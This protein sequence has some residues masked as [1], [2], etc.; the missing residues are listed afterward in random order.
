MKIRSVTCFVTVDETLS[1][2]SLHQAGGLAQTARSMAPGEGFDVQTTRLAVQP[3]HRILQKTHPVEF[4]H[5]FE[6]S[7]RRTGFDYGALAVETNELSEY[8]SEMLRSTETLFSS[9]RI[10]SREGGIDLLAVQAAAHT[11]CDLAHTTDDGLGNFRFGATANSHAGVPFFPA[12]YQEGSPD[13]FAFATEAAD[14]AVQAFASARDLNEARQS[15]TGALERNGARLL[16]LGEAL[17]RRFGLRFAGI[18]FSLAPFPEEGRSVAAAMEKLTGARFGM[19][20][21]LFAAAFLTDC[22]R[23]ANFRRAGFSGLLLPMME[24][25]TMAMRS[26]E[27]L[28]SLDS[29]LLYSTVCGTGLDTIPLAGDT[30]EEAIAALLLDLATLAVKL[31]KPLTARLIPVPG[32]HGGD[33]THF[34]FEYFANAQAFKIDMDGGLKVFRNDWHVEFRTNAG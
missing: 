19:R 14:L 26:Q 9:L 7:Y 2:D 1:S 17:E 10:A 28:Y 34:S 13:A 20:G 8:V 15:L 12:A 27:G 4:A 32:V 23:R 11:I 33:I 30:G 5:N 25:W 24:D 6:K 22:L 18:D 31:D 21:T 16:T 3:L 29:L